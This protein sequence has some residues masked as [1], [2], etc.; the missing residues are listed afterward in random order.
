MFGRLT[1]LWLHTARRS[2]ARAPFVHVAYVY[3]PASSQRN[4]SASAFPD[5]LK[6]SF[7]LQ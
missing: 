7:M 3:D 6:A 4:V 2:A 5:Q 1:V